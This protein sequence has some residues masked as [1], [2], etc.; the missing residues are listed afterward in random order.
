MKKGQPAGRQGFTLIE[1]L[2]SATIIAVLS[3]VGVASYTSINKR[4]RDAKR[5]SDLEQVRSALEMYRTDNGYYPGSSTGFIQLT[6]LDNGSG[7][8]PLVSTYMLS[9]PMDPK[10]TSQIPIT[11]FY[12]PLGTVAPFY[13]YCICANLE[14]QVGISS[15]CGAGVTIPATSCNYGLKNP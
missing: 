13:S 3:V 12:S 6:L 11:Y 14:S 5:K 2:V 7:S 8:G 10:S 1:I 15:T 4:S 9:V